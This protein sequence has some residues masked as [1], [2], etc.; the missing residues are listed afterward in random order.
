[1][2][3]LFILLFYFLFISYFV[4]AQNFTI[5]GYVTDAKSGETL[6]SSSIY[7]ANTRKGT[8]SNNYGFYSLT[9]PKGEVDI[10][11]TYVGFGTQRRI[12][13]LT[14]DTLI[15]IKLTESI[16]LRE[17]TVIGTQRELGVKGSQMSAIEIPI[18]MI[19]S[20]PTLFGEADIIKALQL[21]P[22]VQAGTEG[23]AGFYV[24]GGGPDENLFLLD[25]VPV[26]NVN[27]MG[28]FF[29]VF[30][31]DAIKNVTLYKGAFPARFGGRLSS[32]LDIRMNDGNNKAIHGNFSVGVISSKFNLEGPLFSENTTFNISA[33]R[34]YLDVLMQPLIKLVA[35]QQNRDSENQ[36]VNMTAGYYFYDMNAKISHKFSDKD[37][38]YLSAYI[39]DDVVYAN[40]RQSYK[41]LQNSTEE[42][43]FKLNWDWGNIITALRWNHIINNKLFMNTT[44][45]YTRY[46][47][48]MDVGTTMKQEIKTPP[49][50]INLSTTLGYRSGIEDYGAKVDFDYAPNPN[51]DIKFGGSYTNHTFR[52]G[53]SVAQYKLQNDSAI[54]KMDTTIG[55]QSIFS[56]ETSL[57]IEDNINIGS[58]IKA[59]IGLHYSTFYVQQEFYH[60]LQ[61][62]LGVRVLLTDQLSLK[63]GYAAMNQYIHLL[64]NNTISLPTD[65]WV[66]VTKRIEPMRSHQYSAGVFYNLLN[67]VDLSLEGY[68]KSMHNLIEYKDG[69]TFLG[70][71]TGWEDKVSMGDGWAYG[72]EFLAQKSIG[73]TTGWIGYT[74]SKSERLFNREGQELNNGEVFPAKYDRRHDFSL[75]VS[76]KFS[77]RIDISGTWVYS[78]GNA[79]TLG[80]QNYNAFPIPGNEY[81]YISSL[82]YINKRNNY[83]F[84]DYH[85]LDVGVNFHKQKKHGRRTWN[86][87][88]YNAYNQ[89]NPFLIYT[90]TKTDHNISTNTFTSRKVL[91][92]LTLFPVIPSISYA[93]KF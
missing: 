85:R 26:Y 32:V 67:M 20:V 34:T 73:K 78:T 81:S 33:R 7:D 55:D 83:R 17:V 49:S 56:H 43:R 11:Y 15:N 90:S 1:M 80:L 57:Y 21:L 2:K 75:V 86:I 47:F 51:H 74:W 50:K 39:G 63:A 16:E 40:L 60:S 69:A 18:S 45:T 4:S 35:A 24:R 53:V 59:N 6:I 91:N 54:Q 27:H 37:R 89:M 13:K 92:K 30:N 77:D 41:D 28:G 71:S 52:P 68:Y 70:T 82:P 87:S 19:K 62:R 42:T 93:Y 10:Q 31:P 38:L 65:L 58:F 8:V 3:K 12:F 48:N 36:D 46:R 88:V 72:V 5:S 79:G 84:P 64:S 22:G 25:G 66:P 14:K 23:S 9:L 61:P 76:H 44:A 29:S